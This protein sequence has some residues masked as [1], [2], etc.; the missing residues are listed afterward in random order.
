[1]GVSGKNHAKKSPVSEDP[2]TQ[3]PED[4]SDDIRKADPLSDYREGLK[5]LASAAEKTVTLTVA[6]ETVQGELARLELDHEQLLSM[7]VEGDDDAG[8]EE[9]TRISTKI[10]IH[11]RKI[12]DLS[13]QAS[14]ARSDQEAKLTAVLS[15]FRNLFRTFYSWNFEVQKAKVADQ[16]IP[17]TGFLL[18]EQCVAL[19]KVMASVKALEVVAND[20]E[21]IAAQAG[22]L[23]AACASTDGFQ[24]PV[25]SPPPPVGQPSASAAPQEDDYIGLPRDDGSGQLQVDSRNSASRHSLMKLPRLSEASSRL[26]R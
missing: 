1:M 15:Q 23:L 8:V 10:E 13:R 9:L 24:L 11:R 17:G 16:M 18:I 22:V 12:A 26:A 25:Y 4:H 19:S 6:C 7:A 5:D 14:E 21:G 20:P 2:P 3:Q